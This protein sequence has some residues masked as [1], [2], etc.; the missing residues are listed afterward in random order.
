[1]NQISNLNALKVIGNGRVAQIVTD[2]VWAYKLYPSWYSME[3]IKKEAHI[4]NQIHTLTKLKSVI[5]DVLEDE[6]ALKMSLIRGQTI[7][8]MM[9]KEKFKD[10][11]KCLIQAQVEV[12]QY[13]N[14]ELEDA[15]TSFESTLRHSSLDVEVKDIALHSL[16]LIERKYHLCHFDMHLENIMMNDE[17]LVILDWMNAKLGNP[18]MDIAR[19]YIILI[20]YVKRQANPYLNQICNTMNIPIS[21][22]KQAV[23]LMAALRMLEEESPQAKERLMQL[24]C[25]S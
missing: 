3:S 7:A 23:P 10:G 18:V 19:S 9:R 8:D 6:H 5:C 1:M 16:A 12:F 17:G 2:D 15:F 21:E 25:E 22:V 24:I 4:L 13:Q 11:I 14:L 20:Q